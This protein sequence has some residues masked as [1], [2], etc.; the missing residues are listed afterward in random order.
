MQQKKI[1][2]IFLIRKKVRKC[3]IEL[4]D[5]AEIGDIQKIQFLLDKSK[6]II[7]VDLNYP[8]IDYFTALHY[9]LAE[10]NNEIAKLL[11]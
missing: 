2:K 10:R 5:A 6:N 9:A 1:L 4:I 3:N 8:S 7:P 11:I